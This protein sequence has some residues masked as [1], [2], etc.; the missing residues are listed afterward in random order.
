MFSY[1][2]IIKVICSITNINTIVN[3]KWI[4][5]N[6]LVIKYNKYMDNLVELDRQKYV[7]DEI[8]IPQSKQ[9]FKEFMKLN[10]SIDFDERRQCNKIK[11]NMSI[12]QQNITNL[13]KSVELL[14]KNID[15][16]II[17]QWNEYLEQTKNFLITN[18]INETITINNILTNSSL[19]FMFVHFL[20]IFH[21]NNHNEEYFNI[22]ENIKKY[23]D[24]FSL[25]NLFY[26]SDVEYQEFKKKNV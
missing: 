10:K 24:V 22:F 21:L 12:Y 18:D 7:L 19:Y 1:D 4:P 26:V 25:N 17:N 3:D 13:E 16:S 14:E 6:E 11:K 9:L 2:S 5:N 15:H 20:D 8:Y 23:F